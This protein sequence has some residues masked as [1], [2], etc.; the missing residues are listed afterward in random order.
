MTA[1]ATHVTVQDH[2]LPRVFARLG[3]ATRRLPLLR[4]PLQ[5]AYKRYFNG[6]G[7]HARLFRG[8]YP[9]FAAAIAAIPEGRRE[10][11]DNGASA[12]RLATDRFSIRLNDY[13]ILFWLQRLLPH[14]SRIFDWGGNVGISYFSYRKYLANCTELDWLIED[15][16]AVVAL[17][18]EIASL[19]DSPSLRFTES[20]EAL[21]SSDIL[22]AAGSLQFIPEP[23]E[24]LRAQSSLPPH[25]LLSKL[26]VYDRPARVTL[27]NMGT[28]FS[29][30]QLF[31]RDDLLRQFTDLGYELIDEWRDPAFSCRIPFHDDY[32]ISA[33]SGFYF[34]NAA[35]GE[36]H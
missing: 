32:S 1:L 6:I 29:P 8:V 30:N 14:G 27:Q 23:F 33:Y 10:G 9:D 25:V 26:P 35:L 19:E 31:N 22:L 24:Q 17:G 20:L 21:S 5:L 3:R 15:V 16:P 7:G 18:R 13:P 4:P 12:T 36:P 28:A 34:R 11:Y 2:L